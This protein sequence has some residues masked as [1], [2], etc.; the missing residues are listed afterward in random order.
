MVNTIDRLSGC[1]V[2]GVEGS[3][4]ALLLQHFPGLTAVSALVPAILW[5]V[6]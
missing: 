5:A 6:L 1:S 3:S 4:R 2:G